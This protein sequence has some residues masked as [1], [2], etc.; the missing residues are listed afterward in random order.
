MDV[1]LP[2]A[3]VS[4]P[5]C[6]ILKRTLS[7]ISDLDILIIADLPPQ[8]GARSALQ[9]VASGLKFAQISDDILVINRAK[10]PVLMMST[11]SHL[12]ASVFVLCGVRAPTRS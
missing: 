5:T 3:F 1:C 7:P 6:E 4:I 9:Q 11:T 12:G 2:D 10:V 8:F